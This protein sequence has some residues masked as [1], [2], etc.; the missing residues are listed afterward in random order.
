MPSSQPTGSF[1]IMDLEQEEQ[2]KKVELRKELVGDIS[3]KMFIS[4][5]AQELM[6]LKV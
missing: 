5:M 4:G 6:C 3:F 2:G 1:E